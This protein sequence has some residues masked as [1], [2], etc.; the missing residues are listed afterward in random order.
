MEPQNL[1]TPNLKESGSHLLAG[2]VCMV[3]LVSDEIPDR[4]VLLNPTGQ[5]IKDH[6]SVYLTPERKL[7]LDAT[8]DAKVLRGHVLEAAAA[9]IRACYLRHKPAPTCCYRHGNELHYDDGG[10]CGGQLDP[11]PA[12]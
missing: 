11:K 4:V 6:C 9:A 1:A 7:L 8:G 12:I 2:H 5:E 3:L 10:F